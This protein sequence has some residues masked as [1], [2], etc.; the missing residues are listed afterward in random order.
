M[1]T[2]FSRIHPTYGG[3][4]F[5]D[6]AEPSIVSDVDSESA[7]DLDSRT[8][9]DEIYTHVSEE[10]SSQPDRNHYQSLDQNLRASL[11]QYR[12]ELPSSDP[13]NRDTPNT[14]MTN[15]W[16]LQ[17]TVQSRETRTT[18]SAQQALSP[19]AED[20]SDYTRLPVRSIEKRRT[21][22]PSSSFGSTSSC[23]STTRTK[24][25][26]SSDAQRARFLV[27][28]KILFK[29]LQGTDEELSDRAKS[30]VVEVTERHRNGDLHDAPLVELVERKLKP[31]VGEV[32]WR[33][34]THLLKLFEARHFQNSEL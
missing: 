17:W 6:G 26:L 11:S 3:C 12:A 19:L 25:R 28:V 29:H 2:K 22:S 34:A 24:A 10:F 33:Q 30:I 18:Y 23:K 4:D 5:M 16:D 8:S 27:F 7:C 9:C 15:G 32:H 1:D 31:C 21:V 20:C 13:L 14:W